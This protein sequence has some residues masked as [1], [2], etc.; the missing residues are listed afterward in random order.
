MAGEKPS[1]K[2]GFGSQMHHVLVSPLPMESSLALDLDATEELGQTYIA[3]SRAGG[4]GCA[5]I[6][7][8]E[9][10]PIFHLKGLVG[11]AMDCEF[12]S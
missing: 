11:K 1:P 6:G 8:L 4:T 12:R 3:Q 10:P 9:S 5:N 7:T 2:I